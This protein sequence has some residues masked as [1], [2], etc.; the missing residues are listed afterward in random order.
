MRLVHYKFGGYI[1]R[2][3]G[4]GEGVLLSNRLI[5]G[6]V[7]VI[8]SD[9]AKDFD[10]VPHERLLLEARHYGIPGKLRQGYT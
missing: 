1:A 3:R 8:F 5:H 9:F 4:E 2:G 10:S 7:D 6:Q